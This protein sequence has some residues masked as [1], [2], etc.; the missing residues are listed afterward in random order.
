MPRS[1]E[2]VAQW[3]AV[4]QEVQTAAG[5]ERVK[6]L[7]KVSLTELA[8]EEIVCVRLEVGEEVDIEELQ[9]PASVEGVYVEVRYTVQR[10]DEE[11]GLAVVTGA[12]AVDSLSVL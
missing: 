2:A 10:I 12:L 9:V 7:V 3:E 11:V 8:A 6:A 5:Q 4:L 1:F